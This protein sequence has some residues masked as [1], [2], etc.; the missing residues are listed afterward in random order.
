[1]QFYV[2][3]FA[4]MSGFPLPFTLWLSAGPVLLGLVGRELG[5]RV[6][7]HGVQT[8]SCSRWKASS[9][10]GVYQ[11]GDVVIGGLYIVHYVPPNIDSDF[12]QR[13]QIQ[14]CTG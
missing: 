9:S 10:Q 11:D 6:G 13:P 1:M 7:I 4:L 2:V 5:L 8:L 3:Y 12:T 14:S